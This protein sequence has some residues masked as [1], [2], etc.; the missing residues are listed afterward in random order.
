MYIYFSVDASGVYSA[1][2]DVQGAYNGVN[3]EVLKDRLQALMIPERLMKW[4]YSFCSDRQACIA[5][6]SYCSSTSNITYP[7]LLQGWDNEKAADVEGNVH[8][9]RVESY[10]DELVVAEKKRLRWMSSQNGCCTAWPL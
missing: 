1:D 6:S 9:P 10:K 4:I 2:Q 5:F 8:I 7:G 3:K